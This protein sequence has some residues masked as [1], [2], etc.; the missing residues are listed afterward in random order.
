MKSYISLFIGLLLSVSISAEPLLEGRVRLESGQPVVGVQVRLFDLTNLHQSVGTT[1]DETGHFTLSLPA[2]AT[3]SALPQGFAL[4]QNYPNPFNPSTIIPYQI[5]TAAHVRLAVFNL[6]GQRIATLVDREQV[7]GAHTATWTA[8]DETGRAVGAGV[9]IYRLV[10]GGATVSRR[11]VL[12][13]G[14]AGTPAAGAASV[15]PGMS[16]DEAGEQAYGLVVAGPG[17]APYVVRDFRVEAGMAPV[18]VVVEAHPAGKA[19]DD[20][21]AFCDLL[22]ALH[23]EEEGP[24]PRG[25][26]QAALEAPA[27]PTNLRFD[28]PTDS[29]CTVLWDASDGATD[30]DV[31]YKPAVGGRWTNEPHRG[32]GLSNTINDL[33]SGTE[34]RWAV[35]A[36]NGEGPSAWV[37]GPNFTTLEAVSGQETAPA[38]PTNLRFDAPTDSSCTV[39]WDA[40]DGA[41]DY[42]VNYKPAVGGRW[43]NEPHRGTGLSNTINDLQ[44]GTEYRWAVRAENG[45]GPS[46]WVFGPNF[47]TLETVSGQETT[48]EEEGF[49]A[50]VIIPDPNL[51]LLIEAHLSWGPERGGI[52]RQKAR[53]VPIL[54]AE[55][56]GL[57]IVEIR[58]LGH[59][60]PL[61]LTQNEFDRI[62]ESGIKDLTGIEHA[63]NL[64]HL[65]IN[66]MDL[67]ET[68]LSPL[69]GLSSLTF[70]NLSR[71]KISDLSPLVGLQLR[72]A[73]FSGNNISDISP[74]LKIMAPDRYGVGPNAVH[75][76]ANPLSRESIN[77]HIPALRNMGIPVEFS[78]IV[79]SQQIYNDNVFVLPIAEN[80][81]AG[82]LPLADYSAHLYEYFSDQFDFLIFIP[83]LNYYQKDQDGWNFYG[84]YNFVY[85]DLKGIGQGT[86]FVSE[87]GSAQKLQ[88]VIE[89]SEVM[90]DLPSEIGVRYFLGDGSPAPPPVPQCIVGHSCTN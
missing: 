26:A 63:T 90:D 46:A 72:T 83:N 44:S 53:G 10:S 28:A 50:P 11:M 33:Q 7:A 8:T 35:R 66:D 73:D 27:A 67:S 29:S 49:D 62:L 77:T 86:Y 6:L 55:M 19:L 85:N 60:P 81:A 79:S 56:E 84:R 78:T 88:G 51:R 15:V 3:R 58:G 52:G 30:Y 89:L 24:G 57:W 82:N 12:I 16:E 14:Q 65:V 34:Y 61:G 43:T 41:T 54:K 17:I 13:D 68:D 23:D 5:P 45:E 4:G 59:V 74:L 32:T 42:D 37:F 87:Y 47:T 25:K 31:N 71:T 80:L 18:E 21:C 64:M 70:L 38:A 76:Y 69:A 2:A 20:D 1:T 9:Y 75:L 39:L 36:E 48:Q 22:D 40:S